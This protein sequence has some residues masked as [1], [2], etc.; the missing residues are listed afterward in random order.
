MWLLFNGAQT[1]SELSAKL[2]V[3]QS[4]MSHHLQVLRRARLVKTKRV[5]KQV[6][7]RLASGTGFGT[8]V[9]ALQLLDKK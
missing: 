7:Y 3:E 6:Y 5:H 8:L 2:G 1:V 4:A 9:E